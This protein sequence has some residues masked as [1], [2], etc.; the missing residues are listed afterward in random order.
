MVGVN[1]YVTDQ[2]D[3][4]EI[5]KVDPQ[6]EHDQVERLKAFKADRD[7]DAVAKRLEELR[8][9]ARGTENLLVPIRAALADHATIGEVSGVMREEFGEYQEA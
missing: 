1:E 8:E 6:T 7:Q 4:V 2:I 5:L 3:D 9:T